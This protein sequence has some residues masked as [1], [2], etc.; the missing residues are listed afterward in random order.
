M[1]T[2]FQANER[3]RETEKDENKFSNL[4]LTIVYRITGRPDIAIATKPQ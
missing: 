2:S 3:E 4:I 1:N